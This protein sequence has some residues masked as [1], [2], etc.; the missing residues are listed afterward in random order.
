MKYPL[1]ISCLKMKQQQYF[2]KY[3]LVGYDPQSEK[4]YK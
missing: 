1:H 2:E 3:S 4:V